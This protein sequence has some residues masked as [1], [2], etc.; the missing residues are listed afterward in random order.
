MQWSLLSESV[1]PR[2][3]ICYLYRLSRFR[4]RPISRQRIR[5]CADSYLYDVY[6]DF[7]DE[8][9]GTRSEMAALSA[10]RRFP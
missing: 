10:T 3:L 6:S 1:I 4:A 5:E 7:D 9:I 8:Q 2:V